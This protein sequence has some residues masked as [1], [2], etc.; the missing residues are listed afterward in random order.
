M[1]LFDNSHVADGDRMSAENA[2][3]SHNQYRIYIQINPMKILSVSLSKSNMPG[4]YFVG[5]GDNYYNLVGKAIGDE[6][7]IHID[8]VE[9]TGTVIFLE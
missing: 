1:S 9:F 8:G 6:V 2:I 7:S 5:G 3:I 4:V